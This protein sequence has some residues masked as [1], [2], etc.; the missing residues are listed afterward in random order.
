MPLNTQFS[1][2][3]SISVRCIAYG[4]RYDVQLTVVVEKKGELL[5]FTPI[6]ENR[7]DVR[8]NECFCPLMCFD[9][10]AGEKH[11]DA[12]Y[13]PFGLGQRVEDPYARLESKTKAYYEHNEYETFWHLHYPQASMCWMGIESG[14]QFLY[15]S[16]QDPKIR[17]CFLTVR[18]TIHGTAAGSN[19]KLCGDPSNSAFHLGKE[20]R[21]T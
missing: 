13:M 17:C 8:V 2:A 10:I 4:D 15:I 14:D 21:R 5:S 9:G 11:K 1:T 18:H 12:L 19:E 3:S 20:R 6:V 16:R 7:S